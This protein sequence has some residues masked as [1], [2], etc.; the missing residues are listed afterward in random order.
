LD[1]KQSSKNAQSDDRKEDRHAY[2]CSV[3]SRQFV[4]EHGSSFVSTRRGAR[5][6]T[7][8]TLRFAAPAIRADASIP[9]VKMSLTMV[10][11]TRASRSQHSQFRHQ[12][13]V[14]GMCIPLRWSISIELPG[15]PPPP[16]PGRSLPS[17]SFVFGSSMPVPTELRTYATFCARRGVSD[18]PKGSCCLSADSYINIPPKR[19]NRKQ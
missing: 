5:G 1:N 4:W 18:P 8:P 9:R 13:P 2:F 12:S 3:L 7:Y 16:I 11:F 17:K 10:L 15:V 6:A 14:H 19:Y